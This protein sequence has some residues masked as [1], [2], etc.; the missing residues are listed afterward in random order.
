[1]RNWDPQDWI[2][3]AYVVGASGVLLCFGAA[4]L[5]VASA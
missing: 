1:M 4:L 5:V 3:L 2:M